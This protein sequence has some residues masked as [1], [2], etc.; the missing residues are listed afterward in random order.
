MI[1]F[2][3]RLALAATLSCGVF[4]A[5]AQVVI[6]QVYGGGGNGGAT[7]TNDFIELHNNG[8]TPVAIDGWSV[9]YAS[10]TGTSWNNLTPLAGTI[11]A[12]GYYLVQQGQGSG[13]SAALP[14]PDATG[15]IAMSGSNGKVLLSSAASALTGTCP[16]ATV[17]DQVGYG[18]ADCFEGHGATPALTS[19]TAAI[20]SGGGCTDGNDNAAD[21]AT[22]DPT[23]RNSA[24]ATQVCGGPAQTVISIPDTSA[25]EGNTGEKSFFFTISLNQ[26]AGQGG[27]EFDYRTIDGTATIA[28]GDYHAQ[29]GHLIIIP[30]D[31]S[32]TTSITVYGDAKSEPDETFFVDL[33]NPVGATIA[34]ARAT[35]T[36]VNDDVTLVPIS[37]I[38]G[39]GAMSP[40]VGQSVYARGIVTGRRSNGY[41]I[42]TPDGQ[43]DDDEATSE[44]LYVFTN[45]APPADAAVGNLV[46]VQGAVAEFIP[47]QDP[48]QLPLTE[49]VN[50]IFTVLGTGNP[51]PL[52]RVLTSALPSPSGALDQL[53]RYEGMRVTAESFT[54]VAPTGG[55]TSEPN[56]TGTSN[57][58]FSVVVAG[59]PRPFREPG[60]QTPD[61]PPAGSIPPIPRFDAN[62]ETLTVVSRSIGAETLDVRA[63]SR[64]FKLVGPLDYSFRHYTIL[65][66][67]AVPTIVT[68]RPEPTPARLPTPDEFTVASYNAERFFDTINDPAIGEPVLTEI[69][70]ANRL[71]KA[72][73]AIRDYLNSPDIIGMVEI[74]NLS[75][76]QAIAD[77]V[78]SHG[79]P[80]VRYA[81]YLQEGN[82]VGGI[83]VGFL[84]NEQ[85]VA[86][87]VPRVEVIAV[88]QLGKATTFVQP[89]GS[90]ALLNDR[91]PLQLDSVV[92]Y[93]DGR[94]FPITAMVIHNRSLNGAN[95]NDANGDR[96][97][98]KRQKQ[99]ELVARQVQTLQD[100][101]PAR[102]IVL[103]GDF[104]AFE[105][106]D[107]FGDSMGTI[108]GSPAPDNETVVPGD[109]GDLVQPDLLNLFIE[110]PRNQQYSFVFDGNAQSLDHILINQALGTAAVAVG[111]DHARINADFTEVDRND[112]NSPARLSD[113]DPAVAYIKIKPLT[114]ANLSAFAQ[115]DNNA[116]VLAGKQLSFTSGVQNFGPDNAVFPGIGFAIDAA[117]PDL[118]VTRRGGVDL[119][120][121]TCDSP[122]VANGTT[123]LACT[124]PE[125]ASNQ[126]VFF[127]LRATAPIARANTEITLVTAVSSQNFD[128][129]TT[130]DTATARAFVVSNA[131][132]AM[133]WTG[134]AVT[135]RSVDP[136]RYVATLSNVGPNAASRAVVRLRSDA[137]AKF[138]SLTAPAGWNCEQ[139]DD[140]RFNVVCA[141]ADGVAA[142][143]S[144]PFTLDVVTKGR[145]A[146][147][148]F[149]LRAAVTAD[150]IE[151]DFD[152]N[153]ASKRVLV[154]SNAAP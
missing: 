98:L 46:Q 120:P 141:M 45:A 127:E 143:S 89:D 11:A 84:V 49:M 107:G 106:N 4:A 154:Q 105:F 23:P 19:V 95:G 44:G 149:T 73:L 14:T 64:I 87:G 9:Q 113:H 7:L 109:G 117:L 145:L 81:A 16:T 32:V 133:A 27:V 31:S 153:V 18:S 137:F 69:A 79:A 75:T 115:A 76:L 103:M 66:D 92:H 114:T 85:A 123:S 63:G 135:K 59:T 10:E 2:A 15:T 22:G 78:N 30:G 65:P 82:D 62:P 26:P 142:G 131:D 21:F 51:L 139:L 102:R 36:I 93:A 88:T 151:P 101:D 110:E 68:E 71:D 13:G 119:F 70:F 86:P 1:S 54:V 24:T 40:V 148:L 48:G 33:S 96:V 6:S 111:L 134:E 128:P 126:D 39:G 47:T 100:A 104:N 17:V 67:P 80:G 122:T 55:N 52:P 99:A 53:E 150:S 147:P 72:A 138:V 8:D 41:Y 132:L 37:R 146:P 112:A 152:N 12:G 91:P 77:A 140:R 58:I 38:Q 3:R 25:A 60:I 136:A 50:S 20:R 74:E 56:A 43:D 35:G 125:F 61:L 5:H 116:P 42:Q 129:V 130:N 121:W 28:D 124:T 144:T 97:R 29:S 118:V 94:A 57:G 83:D 34:K 90:S 108:A